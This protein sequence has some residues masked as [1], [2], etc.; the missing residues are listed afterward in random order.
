M[1]LSI[2][3][4]NFLYKHAFP[5]Y[6]PLYSAFKNKQDAFEIAL[7]RGH[8]KKSDVVLDI[9]ANIGYY[10][11]I[12]SHLVGDDGKVYCFEP[13]NNNFNHLKQRVKDLNNVVINQKAVSSRTEKIK[14]YTSK[15]LNVDHRTYQ[16]EEYENVFDIDAVSIDDYLK[17]EQ[18]S[19]ID[20]IKIDIQG[21]EMQAI[22]GMENTLRYNPKIKI[23]SEFW[24]YG[25]KGS[26]SSA[27]AYFAYLSHMGFKIEL[28]NKQSLK[29][30]EEADVRL[31]ENLGKEHYFNIFAQR[32]V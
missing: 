23:I 3:L 26:G 22:Q 32:H 13:D 19:F 11:E 30:L 10:A 6:E 7:L 17:N 1:S 29:P 12:L 21:F 25:L 16:P 2:K 5:L 20:F 9:G 31:L 8:I 14:I 28:L 4:G 27:M 18:H 15:E 24:P